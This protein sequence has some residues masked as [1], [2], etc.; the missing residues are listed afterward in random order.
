M[1]NE[2]I[3][4]IG[5]VIVYLSFSHNGLLKEIINKVFWKKIRLICYRIEKIRNE[6]FMRQGLAIREN[7]DEA[8]VLL[9][10]LQYL[11]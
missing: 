7:A 5:P 1:W 8:V 11:T 10:Y 6:I 3:F 2:L 9:H 4:M